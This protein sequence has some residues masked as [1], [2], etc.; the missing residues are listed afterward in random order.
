[1]LEDEKTPPIIKGKTSFYLGK[2]GDPR[3]FDPMVQVIEAELP[4]SMDMDEDSA[5]HFTMVGLG[6]LG[7]DDAFSYLRK[8]AGEDYWLQRSS[9][10]TIPSMSRDAAATR[11][12]F[13]E[14]AVMALG[15]SGKEKAAEI[16]ED[17]RRDSAADIAKK[18][19]AAI[20]EVEK[21][22]K[23][24]HLIE[25]DKYIPIMPNTPATP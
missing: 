24:S 15:F 18:V 5:L 21:R 20:A 19:N 3:A 11:R 12:G 16:L 8:L 23:G 22:Q 13:R 17:L 10:P 14:S 9:Q 25:R 1:M 4:E 6:F 2:I 7:T